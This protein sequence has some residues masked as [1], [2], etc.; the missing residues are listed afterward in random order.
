MEELPL[1]TIACWK[2][3]IALQ[4]LRK[5]VLF[6]ESRPSRAGVRLVAVSFYEVA[7]MASTVTA[8]LGCSPFPSQPLF[9]LEYVLL[10]LNTHFQTLPLRAL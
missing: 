3:K 7:T 6:N 1:V 2:P 10:S 4:S 8:D 5:S 9:P